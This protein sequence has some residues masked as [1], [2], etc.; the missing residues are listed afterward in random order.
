V[1]K[2]SKKLGGLEAWMLESLEAGMPES[3]AIWKRGG[4]NL[5]LAFQPYS[6]LASQPSI[7]PA[8]QPSGLPSSKFEVKL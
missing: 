5:I 8:S 1:I 3:L 7:F 2:G 6:F 4:L